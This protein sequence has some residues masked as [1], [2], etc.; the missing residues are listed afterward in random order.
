M[1]YGTRERGHW[2]SL[3]GKERSP[4]AWFPIP[5]YEQPQECPSEEPATETEQV[6]TVPEWARAL[7]ELVAALVEEVTHTR[8]RRC[9]RETHDH[10]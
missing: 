7:T 10:Y 8:S 5:P 9:H 1:F 2:L 3:D 4:I 6:E